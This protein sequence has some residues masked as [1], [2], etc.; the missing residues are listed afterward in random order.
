MRAPVSPE[1]NQL[2]ALKAEVEAAKREASERLAAASAER[3]LFEKQVRTREAQM[4]R[5]TVEHNL[6]GACARF[7]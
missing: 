6:C 4:K 2:R 5:D 7:V 3:A 1:A